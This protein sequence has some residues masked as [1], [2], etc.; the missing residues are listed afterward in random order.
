VDDALVIAN[1]LRPVLLR[2]ARRLRR[3]LHDL[4]VT[5]IQIS[6][7]TAIRHQPGI[8][9]GELAGREGMSSASLSVH[10]DRLQSAGLVDRARVDDG[11][12]RRVWLRITSA[13]ETLLDAARSRRTA[14]LA[15]RLERLSVDERSAVEAAID[16]L[17]RLLEEPDL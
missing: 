12:R 16:P 9:L 6:L 3:E 8:G 14:W 13:G 10:I 17:L 1:R 4:D 7:L 15:R 2:L 5:V 11:D